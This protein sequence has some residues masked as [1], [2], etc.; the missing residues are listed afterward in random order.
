MGK[1]LDWN[2]FGKISA[3]DDEKGNPGFFIIKNDDKELKMSKAY[4]DT[5]IPWQEVRDKVKEYK[6]ED[7]CVELATSHGCDPEKWFCDIRP[8]NSESCDC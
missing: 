6:K 4:P 5:S 8:C 3:Y 2:C 7:K 1:E